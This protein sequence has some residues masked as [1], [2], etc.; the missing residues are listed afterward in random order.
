M[1]AIIIIKQNI[2]S[3]LCRARQNVP[4]RCHQIIALVEKG[5]VRQS[6]SRDDDVIGAFTKNVIRLGVGVEAEGG[7][8][9]LA[10][11][12]A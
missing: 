5:R 10:F 3:R 11:D 6:A 8:L 4:R 7:A 1:V 9:P 12:G 2:F